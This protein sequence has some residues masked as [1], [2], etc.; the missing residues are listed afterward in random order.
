[1][2][3]EKASFDANKSWYRGTYSSDYAS[4]PGFKVNTS[5]LLDIK[6]TTGESE[7]VLTNER[8]QIILAVKA[9]NGSGN[10]YEG[11]HFIVVNRSAL[12]NFVKYDAAAADDTARYTSYNTLEE[13]K[14][15][16]YSEINGESTADITSLSDYFT[17]NIPSSSNFPK[18]AGEKVKST[19][20]NRVVTSD[21]NYQ[22]KANKISSAV[23]H[24]NSSEDTY[25]FQSLIETQNLTFSTSDL[26]KKVESLIKNYI[27]FTRE[28]NHEDEIKTLD[29]AWDTYAEV[30]ERQNED[31]DIADGKQRLISEAV[32]MTYFGKDARL[33]E[34]IYDNGGIGYDGK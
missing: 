21:K 4:L 30:L 19:Y 15:A 7:N 12:D 27:T 25:E 22:E 24:Y 13:A 18:Y 17:V 8:G 28:K 32:A 3:S 5:D 6:S 10:A 11:L 16:G 33:G 26:G 2:A 29:D 34:G 31:R 20:V 9:S 1:M 14:A 23:K